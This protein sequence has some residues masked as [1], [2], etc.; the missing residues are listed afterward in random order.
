VKDIARHLRVGAGRVRLSRWDPDSTPGCRDRAEAAERTEANLARIDRLQ[1]ELH[2]EGRRSL[3]IVLQGMDTAGKDGLIRKVMTAFNPQGCR[4]TPFKVPTPLEAAHDFLW[5]I[6]QAA[7]ARGEV[8]IFN[9]S[10]YEDVLVVR[11]HGLVPRPV[12]RRRYE[13]I[14]R[15]ELHLQEHG[16][17]VVKFFLHISRKEQK[18]RL[19]ARLDDPR[20]NWKFSETDIAERAHW[21][22]YHRAYEDALSQCSP[23]SA[24][25]YVIPANAKWYRNLAVSEIVAGALEEMA[26]RAPRVKL[27]IGRLR[28][29]LEK[30]DGR[31]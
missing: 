9:R 23:A 7:P 3:L 14:N 6:H 19:L 28:R 13:G 17:R 18:K 31:A 10:H 11:V 29:R 5:R 22:A 27:D 12:W 21:G 4:V 15:F 1:Y 24:P 25:W 2:A 30:S 8:A 20:K 16:T 26:P